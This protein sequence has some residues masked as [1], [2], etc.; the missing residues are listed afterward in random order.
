MSDTPSTTDSVDTLKDAYEYVHGLVTAN[1][2]EVIGV[3]S[4]YKNKQL[5]DLMGATAGVILGIFDK[6]STDW[7]SRVALGLEYGLTGDESLLE[8]VKAADDDDRPG[9]Y[10]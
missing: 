9:Q 2:D 7:R 3:Q 1:T 10:L 5:R 4:K 6:C 8:K